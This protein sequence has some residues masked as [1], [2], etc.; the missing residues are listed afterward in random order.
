MPKNRSSLTPWESHR[1][2]S[3]GKPS[4]PRSFYLRYVDDF[5]FHGDPEVLILKRGRTFPIDELPSHVLLA[6]ERGWP[7]FDE[8]T[9]RAPRRS[10]SCSCPSR[11]T[12]SPAD[13]VA[14][15]A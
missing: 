12:A 11:A 6:E 9:H 3:A 7:R 8:C 5:A 4:S 14:S 15:T 10:S 13:G 1:F 2:K